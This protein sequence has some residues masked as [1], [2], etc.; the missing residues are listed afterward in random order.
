MASLI[1]RLLFLAIVVGGPLAG[2]FLVTPGSLGDERFDIPEAALLPDRP[3]RLAGLHI[4][5]APSDPR[6]APRQ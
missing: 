3:Q 6:I 4:A 5:E 1:H 2:G